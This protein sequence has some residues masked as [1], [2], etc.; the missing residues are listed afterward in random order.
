MPVKTETV[1]LSKDEQAQLTISSNFLEETVILTISSPVQDFRPVY[2]E[3]PAE[4]LELV[5]QHLAAIYAELV[6][7]LGPEPQM[8]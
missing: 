5:I 4:D 1:Y 8:H 2:L 7:P 3:L 6:T